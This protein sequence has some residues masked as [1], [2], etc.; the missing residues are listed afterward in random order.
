MYGAHRTGLL[1]VGRG[2]GGG[3][4][5]GVALGGAARPL[6]GGA[7]T[8]RRRRG[9]NGSVHYRSF[10]TVIYYAFRALEHTPLRRAVLHDY[11]LVSKAH[12]FPSC[13]PLSTSPVV[14]HFYASITRHAS[15][16]RARCDPRSMAR[17][18][19]QF[20]GDRCIALQISLFCLCSHERHPARLALGALSHIYPQHSCFRP[21]HFREL[22][23]VRTTRPRVI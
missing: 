15:H 18:L 13:I 11:G 6:G 4:G 9:K 7:A 22:A 21:Q 3:V 10:G 12:T 1:G 2:A 20:G 14:T 16:A 23:R 8:A 5:E 17:P 19:V